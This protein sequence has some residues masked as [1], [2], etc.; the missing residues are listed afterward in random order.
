V[1]SA[2][3]VGVTQGVRVV[4]IDSLGVERVILT[5]PGDTAMRCAANHLVRGILGECGGV[6]AC[7]TCHGYVADAWASKLP[8]PTKSE[9]EMLSGCIDRRPNSRLTCQIRLAAEL[10]G[11][12][13][14]VPSAQT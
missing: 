10:D 1:G 3:W 8:P 9:E 13:I 5:D 7:G 4:F 12:T 11:L 6:M 2:L 14:R